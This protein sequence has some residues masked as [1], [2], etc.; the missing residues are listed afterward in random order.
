MKSGPVIIVLAAGLGSRF[1][2]AGHKL[3]QPLG[4][5][6]VLGATLVQALA[7]GL[8]LVVVTTAA[9]AAEAARHVAS[10]DIVVMEASVGEGRLQPS[11]RSDLRSANVQLGM[12]ASIAAGVSARS[13]AAG[14]LVLPGDMPLLQ[15]TTLQ[16]VAQALREHPIAYAQVDG[17][18][19]HPVGFG[20]EL[21]SELITL[22]GDEGARRLV[23]RYP[24]HAVDVD[25]AGALVDVD[26][27]A[28]LQRVRALWA[29]AASTPG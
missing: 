9:L 16:R 27:V 23:S 17:H 8:S 4:G 11:D 3:V 15:A 6:S 29:R 18:R 26:T 19:G 24:A 1:H 10:Q 13:D 21:Y 14:W 20:A 7:S 12:G 22:Q 28:D 2:D 25:D 5:T